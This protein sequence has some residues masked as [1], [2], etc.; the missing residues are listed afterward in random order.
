MAKLR[1]LHIA[2]DEKFFD[3]VYQTFER[4]SR[5]ENKALLITPSKDYELKW[6]TRRDAVVEVWNKKQIVDFFMSGQYDVVYFYSLRP[7]IWPYVPFIPSN[8]TV[9]W[10]LFGF[11]VY[12][13]N[14]GM[15]PLIALDLYKAKTKEIITKIGVEYG[16]K[17]RLIRSIKKIFYQLLLPI[18]IK[19]IDYFQPIYSIE[20][21]YMRNIKGF[22]AEEFYNNNSLYF[23]TDIIVDKPKDGYVLIGNSA[24][25]TNNHLD[26]LNNVSSMKYN[27]LK[28]W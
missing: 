13:S 18:I 16:P 28:I 19:R 27:S 1:V 7:D 6:I 12:A 10:W 23:T 4:D 21:E 17:K 25:D 5:L 8:K 2:C 3:T 20:M 24:S 11:E 9:I 14:Y 26:I 15:R 22:R